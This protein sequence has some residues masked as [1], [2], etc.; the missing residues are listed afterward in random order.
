[1]E[2]D[3]F[4]HRE[5]RTKWVKVVARHVSGSKRISTLA[6]EHMAQKVK[7]L[8]KIGYKIEDIKQI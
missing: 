1:M 8:Q 7:N 3:E 2:F 6:V 4:S 5:S